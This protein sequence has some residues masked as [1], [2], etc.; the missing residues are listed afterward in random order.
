MQ[1]FDPIWHALLLLAS[2]QSIE[3]ERLE[4]ELGNALLLLDRDGHL[5]QA[6]GLAKPCLQWRIAAAHD[7]AVVRLLN[8]LEMIGHFGADF[9]RRPA[10]FI[11]GP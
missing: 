2:R 1:P 10:K 9:V 8:D 11:G 3:E 5:E 7:D 6:V 4:V